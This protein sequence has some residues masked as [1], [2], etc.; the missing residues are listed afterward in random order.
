MIATIKA[1]FQ[2]ISWHR[3]EVE[4]ILISIV[5]VTVAHGWWA[6]IKLNTLISA[7]YLIINF[8]KAKFRMTAL[9]LGRGK[10]QEL[11]G[12]VFTPGSI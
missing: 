9:N 8:S 6:L 11:S 12:I 7:Y 2:I 4:K 3:A 10:V 5:T 1:E